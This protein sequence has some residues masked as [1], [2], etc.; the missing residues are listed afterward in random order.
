MYL[1][2]AYPLLKSL[3]WLPTAMELLFHFMPFRCYK[4]RPCFCGLQRS[5]PEN[6]PQPTFVA[7]LPLVCLDTEMLTGDSEEQGL[8]ASGLGLNFC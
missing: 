8:T 7:T 4:I 5:P 1:L 6:W 2:K 3:P